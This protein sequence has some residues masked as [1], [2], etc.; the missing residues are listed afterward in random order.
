MFCPLG[1]WGC[2]QFLQVLLCGPWRMV[3]AAAEPAP[4][5][6]G[7]HSGGSPTC[8]V[9]GTDP[10]LFPGAAHTREGG[11]CAC[12][13]SWSSSYYNPCTLPGRSQQELGLGFVR[14][15][16][17]EWGVSQHAVIAAVSLRHAPI[18]T[19]SCTSP[20]QRVVCSFVYWDPLARDCSSVFP[21]N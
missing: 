17:L 1:G 6:P 15:A 12:Q 19:H 13:S 21:T 4:D 20:P 11:N 10:V 3:P 7:S 9:Q 8:S 5:S 14:I 2:S 16:G 18:S